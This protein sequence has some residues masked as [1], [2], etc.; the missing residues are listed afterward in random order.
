MLAGE[1]AE[2]I[3]GG[4]RDWMVRENTTIVAVICLVIAVKLLG[5]G[6]TVLTA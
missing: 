3:L 1:G 4:L 2:R 6:V 5:D